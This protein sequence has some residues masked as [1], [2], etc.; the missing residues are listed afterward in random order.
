MNCK[1]IKELLLTDYLDG[2]LKDAL[3]E[4]I[5]NHLEGCSS[6]RSLEESL[7]RQVVRPFKVV[8]ETQAPPYI[9][10]RI[11]DSIRQEKS[12]QGLL[13]RLR[14]IKIPFLAFPRPVFALAT[15]CAIIL[16]VLVLAPKKTYK[17]LDV[18]TYL[19]DQ[20]QFLL[21][22]NLLGDSNSVD[23]NI[24]NILY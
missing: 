14:E 16:I 20:T 5:K 24:E 6:C 18:E 2:E 7:R 12:R 17:P 4:K 13:G 21:E 23:S 15:A 22:L 8:Q 1:K 19:Q 10:E 9:W 3:S 11:K